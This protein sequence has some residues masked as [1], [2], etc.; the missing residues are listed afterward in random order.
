MTGPKNQAVG[1]LRWGMFFGKGRA[2]APV[3]EAEEGEQIAHTCEN[4]WLQSVSSD[5]FP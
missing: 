4:A 5:F 2:D 3:N 1:G